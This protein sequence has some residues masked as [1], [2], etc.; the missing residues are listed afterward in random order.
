MKKTTIPGIIVIA[1]LTLCVIVYIFC[2]PGNAQIFGILGTVMFSGITVIVLYMTWSIYRE[3][4]EVS[5][6]TLKFTK[7]QTSFNSYFDNF[8]L[9][10]DLSKR[11]T[12]IVLIGEIDDELVAFFKNMTFITI[13]IDYINILTNFP[14]VTHGL[15]RERDIKYE[16]VFKRF[17]YKIQSFINIIYDEIVKI[18][19]DSNLTDTNKTTLIDLYNNFVLSDYINLSKDLIQNIEMNK[20]LPPTEIP[21]YLKCNYNNRSIFD[22]E[23][24]LKL[25]YEVEKKI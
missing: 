23:E 9:F 13:H 18:K 11:N 14:K 4:L 17:N 12:S 21:D 3:I 15:N 19:T 8:K 7:N 24:F 1:I 20:G 16:N 5:K 6:H 22:I 2:N 25:H 10:D